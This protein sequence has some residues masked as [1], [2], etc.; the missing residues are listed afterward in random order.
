MEGQLEL[1]DT[2]IINLCNTIRSAHKIELHRHLTGSISAETA[3]KIALKHNIYLPT[4]L[5]AELEDHLVPKNCRRDLEEYFKPWETLNQ[6]FINPEAVYELIFNVIKEASEDNIIYLELRTGPRWFLG[7]GKYTFQNFLQSF[8]NASEDAEKEFGIVTR[9]IIGLPRQ[10]F[11]KIP[12]NIIHKMFWRIIDDIK[13]Y[14][15]DII[16]GID[17]NGNEAKSNGNAFKGFFD[18]GRR[19][20]LRITIHAGELGNIENVQY[21]IS[22]LG[23]NRIGHGIALFN[24]HELMNEIKNLRIPMEICPSS[25]ILLQIATDLNYIP[26]NYLIENNI[27]FAIC[28]DNPIICKTSLSEE[29]IKLALFFSLSSHNILALEN[30]KIDYIFA[31]TQV[32]ENISQRLMPDK[33]MFNEK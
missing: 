8:I 22:D 31:S 4:Y 16:V 9:G 10:V 20:G 7:D 13:K 33:L 19:A 21:A 27:P 29:L 12:S 1:F 26:L 15:D 14:G 3:I 2:N 17:L 24:E 30:K 11:I 6:L 25:N 32:K 28:T 18:L 23:A 5:R